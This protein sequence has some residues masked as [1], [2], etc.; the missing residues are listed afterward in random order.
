MLNR[1]E[2]ENVKVTGGVFRERMNLDRN[3]LLELD[4]INCK[5]SIK[6]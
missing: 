6:R 1:V 2:K 4:K 5:G 3:Y